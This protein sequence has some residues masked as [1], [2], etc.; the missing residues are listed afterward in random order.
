MCVPPANHTLCQLLHVSA[1]KQH[2]TLS[3]SQ[4]GVNYLPI[5]SISNLFIIIQKAVSCVKLN[6]SAII[7]S[8]LWIRHWVSCIMGMIVM[9]FTP[10]WLL[11][12][13]KYYA[14]L[15]L[16]SC[17]WLKS[18]TSPGWHKVFFGGGVQICQ[19]ESCFCT[20]CSSLWNYRNVLNFAGKFQILDKKNVTIHLPLY[21]DMI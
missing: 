3:I 5:T 12:N 8:N 1:F 4:R 7:Q 2:S 9:F 11:D 15:W 21:T 19:I 13:L 16:F 20:C 18:D 14:L 6:P 10:C 17:C